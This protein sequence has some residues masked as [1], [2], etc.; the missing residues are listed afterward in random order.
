MINIIYNISV[1]YD[2][3]YGFQVYS[4]DE[5]GILKVDLCKPENDDYVDDR[6]VSVRD[7]LVFL[8]L[9]CFTSVYSKPQYPGGRV[10]CFPAF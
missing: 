10:F 5:D 3:I 2:V 7:A 1:T 6:P 4:Q 9:A 8:E